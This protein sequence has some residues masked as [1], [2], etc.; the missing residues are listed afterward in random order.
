MYEVA[1]YRQQLG[2]LQKEMERVSLTTIDLNNALS[3][4]KKLEQK[5]TI[6]PI[7]GGTYVK[8]AI[9]DTKVIVP[10]GAQYLREMDQKDAIAEIER[11]QEAT[12]RAIVKLET[13]FKKI[14]TK[15]QQVS[16]QLKDME[17]RAKISKRVDDNIGED[18][19]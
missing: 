5:E 9:T 1:L 13:E 18:Y 12:K 16:S 3:T 15:F 6:V 11:R 10:I 7:G 17:A 8:A 2:M 4:V 14:A 19:I